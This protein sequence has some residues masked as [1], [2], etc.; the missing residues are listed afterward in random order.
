MSRI[1]RLHFRAVVGQ[2]G[3]P[4]AAMFFYAPRITFASEVPR[5]ASANAAAFALIIPMHQSFS[6]NRTSSHVAMLLV[7]TPWHAPS[8][9]EYLIV[10]IRQKAFSRTWRY[11]WLWSI[12][13]QSHGSYM[14][15]TCTYPT[16]ALV[17]PL[18][19]MHGLL[20]VWPISCHV[21]VASWLPLIHCSHRREATSLQQIDA[22]NW[23]WLHILHLKKIQGSLA[24]CHISFGW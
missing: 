10:A 20:L 24:R 12:T 4:R 8:V 19:F 6:H 13:E 5:F 14:Q 15:A 17:R 22:H 23:I 9:P 11:L 2:Q 16:K 21:A 18:A 3:A 1:S 7:C